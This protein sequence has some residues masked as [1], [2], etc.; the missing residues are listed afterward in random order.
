M[1]LLLLADTICFVLTSKLPP[2]CGVVSSTMFAS[3]L[4]VAEA[5]AEPFQ[6]RTSPLLGDPDIEIC[7]ADPSPNAVYNSSKLSFTIS[8]PARRVVPPPSFAL[9]PK[10]IV[11]PYELF[12]RLS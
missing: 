4:G 10:L 2:S 5:K 3:V 12:I 7:S 8:P 6:V 9:D 1:I 11:L